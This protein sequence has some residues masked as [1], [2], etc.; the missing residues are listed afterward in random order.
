MSRVALLYG[1]QTLLDEYNE[2]VAEKL[3][4][5]SSAAKRDS[6]KTVGFIRGMQQMMLDIETYHP[7][8]HYLG[9][10]C[11]VGALFNAK[12][13]FYR[14]ISLL[15]SDL[16]LIFD[17]RSPSPWEVIVE[18][19]TR[20]IIDESEKASIKECLSIANEMRLKAYFAYNRQKEVLSPI[21]Q[22]TSTIGQS[23][24]APIFR[25]FDEDILVHFL[26]TSHDIHSRCHKLC[27]KFHQEG[28]VDISLLRSPSVPSS[29]A[30]LFGYLYFRLQMFPKALEW[31]ASAPEDAVNKFNSLCGKGNIYL[32]CGEY[33]KSVEYFEKA[34]EIRYQYEEPLD[35]ALLA[36][37]NNLAMTL[38]NMGQ[39]KKARV[40]LE[41]AIE[42][43]RQAYG[44]DSETVIL[45]S[46]MLNLGIIY[47]SNDPRSAI[48]TYEVVEGMQSR[49]MNVPNQDA[50]CLSFNM[51][52]SLSKLY[53]LERSLEYMKKAI[54]LG[55][56]VYGKH[57][58]S[59]ELA[60]IYKI[61][62]MV[63]ENCNQNNEA[64]SWFKRSLE[65]HKLVF[66]DSLRPG[67]IKTCS[68]NYIKNLSSCI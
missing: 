29:K 28:E 37:I 66:R 17:T 2:R 65:L 20:A 57:N 45:S 55:H 56:Q 21:P 35:M 31:F 22:Y 4:T 30:N 24:D 60:K 25:D 62:G 47:A 59:S 46:L 32:E 19:C 6:N 38:R 1:K 49:L 64:L 63:Y 67:K 5:K 9:S 48:E 34:L 53:Q 14:L 41:E 11:T 15:L 68:A 26:S 8:N 12:Q 36:C 54:Q 40:K 44:E 3:N 61:A 58:Q 52:F 51:A 33:M 18:L 23:T 27:L 16:G 43:H 42:K 7:N 13:E 10:H 50:I 39:H